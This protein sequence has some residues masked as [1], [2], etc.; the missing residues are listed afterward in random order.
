[1]RLYMYIMHFQVLQMIA[2]LF[3]FCFLFVKSI[4][5]PVSKPIIS[6]CAGAGHACAVFENNLMRCWGIADYIGT[7]TNYGDLPSTVGDNIPYFNPGRSLNITKVSCLSQGVCVL[8]STGVVKCVGMNDNGQVGIGNSTSPVG[9]NSGHVGDSLPIVNLGTGAKISS[10]ASGINHVCV[11]AT[12]NQI[13]CY[14]YNLE[15]ELG[16]GDTTNR[17]TA[18]SHMGDNLP[19]IDLGAGAEAASIY[20]GSTANHNC[21][22]LSAPPASSQRIKCW[23]LNNQ[24]QLGYGD[25]NHRG[26]VGT[27]MGNNLLLIDLGTE[28]KVKNLVLGNWH[29]CALLVNDALKCFGSGFYG[30]LGSGSTSAIS[31]TGNSMPLVSVD[32]GKTVKLM[33]AGVSSSCIAYDDMTSMKCF[34]YNNYGQLGQ[35]DTVNRGWEP[36]TMI[37][38]IPLIDLGTGSLAISSIHSGTYLICVVFV[39]GSVKCFGWNQFGQFAIGSTILAIGDQRYEMGTNL[40][41][42]ELF[43]PTQSPTLPTTSPTKSPTINPTKTPTQSPSKAPTNVPTVSINISTS[44]PTSSPT[45]LIKHDTTIDDIIIGVVVGVSILLILIGII[46]RILI[47]R[48]RKK[49][50]PKYEMVTTTNPA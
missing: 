27:E 14:G 36:T 47:I 40:T 12:T 50:H 35:G 3:P 24:Y 32:S 9:I 18:P 10:V 22:I 44:K 37:P 28:S 42:S 49:K 25:N 2:F 15:G 43:S 23:G 34:G 1:M 33:A 45:K 29:T 20:S 41:F 21:V 19:F 7:S 31:A 46:I 4:L 16:L 5:N 6:F 39:D 30:Q 26:D 11:L 17:G 8:L 48:N 13:K 38:S